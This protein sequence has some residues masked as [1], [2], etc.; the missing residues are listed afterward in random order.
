MKASCETSDELTSEGV[1]GLAAL[2]E[3]RMTYGDD[4][5]IALPSWVIASAIFLAS[6]PWIWPAEPWPT[7]ARLSSL[8]IS[9]KSLAGPRSVMPP[10]TNPLAYS[11]FDK[12]TQSSSLFLSSCATATLRWIGGVY[13]G[14]IR[15]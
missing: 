5:G 6:K 9:E 10:L 2:Q 3:S 1:V 11:R 12:I 8:A 14:S 7:I 4:F 15:A 13:R